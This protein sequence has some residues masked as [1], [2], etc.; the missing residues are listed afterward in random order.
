MKISHIT[1][2]A[3]RRNKKQVRIS[4]LK[5]LME[6]HPSHEEIAAYFG[7]SVSSWK[8]LLEKDEIIRT[9]YETGQ[10]LGKISLRRK[11]HALASHNA[12]M[13]I[14]LGKQILGQEEKSA[15]EVSGPGGKP[16]QS[17]TTVEYDFSKL[18][19]AERTALRESLEKATGRS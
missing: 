13:A 5:S 15:V 16:I 1:G 8:R 2:M 19:D 3:K 11:Q 17:E 9:T 12:S 4:E 10:G 6:L 18:S 14:H 7:I